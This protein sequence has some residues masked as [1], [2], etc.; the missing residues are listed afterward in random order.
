MEEEE[1]KEKKG[2]RQPKN[3]IFNVLKDKFIFEFW[4][5]FDPFL[6]DINLKLQEFKLFIYF[7][8]V[9]GKL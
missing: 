1:R 6:K 8:V 2:I 5:L 7:F 3:S 4:F 9:S